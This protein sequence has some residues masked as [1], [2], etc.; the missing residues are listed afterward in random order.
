MNVRFHFPERF[1]HLALVCY[2]AEGMVILQLK[3]ELQIV[4]SQCFC[5]AGVC[6]TVD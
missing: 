6:K 1:T 2:T 3:E 5:E 4:K